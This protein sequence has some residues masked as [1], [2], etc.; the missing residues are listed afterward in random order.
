MDHK[1]SEEIIFTDYK[2]FHIAGHGLAVSQLTCVDSSA[3][4]KRKEELLHIMRRHARGKQLDLMLLML[5]DVLMDGTLILYVGDD[6][7]IEQAFNRTPRDNEVFL[8]KVMSRKKQIIPM[9]SDLWG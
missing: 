4:L 1:T 5:T 3:V 9:L 6:D 8:P 7:A 2:E